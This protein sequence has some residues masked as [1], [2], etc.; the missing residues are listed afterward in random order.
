MTPQIIKL[1]SFCK[2]VRVPQLPWLCFYC[3]LHEKETRSFNL[4][5]A[6][7]FGRLHFSCS[8]TYIL[9]CAYLVSPNLE[10]K[11]WSPQPPPFSELQVTRWSIPHPLAD[12]SLPEIST[13]WRCLQTLGDWRTGCWRFSHLCMM[14][15]QRTASRGTDA[16]GPEVRDLFSQI[17]MLLPVLHLQVDSGTLLC[18]RAGMMKAELKSTNRSLVSPEGC[19][20]KPQQSD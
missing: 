7:V 11:Q 3:W 15:G 17:H 4:E 9:F 10:D 12:R 6:I 13:M 14:R 20:T 1:F 2:A 8:R 16:V 19:C 18:S 5:L